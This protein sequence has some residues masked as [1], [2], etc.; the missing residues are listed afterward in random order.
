MVEDAALPS[1][2]APPKEESF[3]SADYLDAVDF[4]APIR[5]EN[6][7]D[8]FAFYSAYERA[9]GNLGDR[10]AE[11]PVGAVY[12]LF[13]SLCSMS[14]RPSDPGDDWIPFMS[15]GTVRSA[16]A[17][18]IRGNQ[19]TVLSNI[20]SRISNVVL[21]ARIADICWSNN[22]GDGRAAQVAI[23]AYCEIVFG[24][25]DGSIKTSHGM[26]VSYEALP[27]IQRAIHL[28]LRTTKRIKR[29]E[30][31]AMAFEALHAAAR[32]KHDV[33]TIVRLSSEAMAYGIRQKEQ[34]VLELESAASSSLPG[35]Y[36]EAIRRAWDFAGDLY[37]QLGDHEARQRCL[38]N[39]VDQTIAM[40][41][42]VRGNPAAEAMWLTDALQQLRHVKG[43][44][45][46]KRDLETE[47]RKLQQESTT[48]FSTFEIDLKIGNMPQETTDLFTG[49]CLSKS[50]KGFAMLC[51]SR[52]IERLRA[53]AINSADNS[54]L[55]SLMSGVHY[56]S[57]GRPEAKSSGAPYEGE[58]DESWF[59]RTVGLTER[60]NRSRAV[61]GRIDP[62]RRVIQAHFAIGERHIRPLVELSA[63]VPRSQQMIVILGFVRLFQLDLL[64]AAHLL[65]PQL[66]P[67]LRHILRINGH[68]P[69][70]RRDDSTE[71][72]L[73]LSALFISFR[74]PL[75]KVLGT[76]I[77]SEVDLLFNAKPGPE[78]RH[79]IAHGQLSD[80]ACYDIDAYY[81]CWLIYRIC[82]LFLIPD[83]ERLVAPRL[84]AEE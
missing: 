19:T 1:N 78:L 63:F 6:T 31:V 38:K 3:V 11:K 55:L 59:R 13:G 30:H 75:E 25:L 62:A 20:I 72:D 33:M 51:A 57:N 40:R 34:V 41:E 82:C 58:P 83:W 54:S 23:S 16:V 60:R 74:E 52:S 24:L 49:W 36:P 14:N 53:E 32:D 39:S 48:Q 10:P 37:H 84:T 9:Y 77:A 26:P 21:R 71:E 79:E 47:V 7:A 46:Q 67:C 81:A 69:S 28:T 45:Q 43:H 50:L 4:E 17:D 44:E 27:A 66:E 22:R 2:L 61:V 15:V 56:D 64:S 70:K 29:P 65:I 73:S 80:G 35:T 18:D 42:Q 12:R 68:N 8:M 5:D 76:D